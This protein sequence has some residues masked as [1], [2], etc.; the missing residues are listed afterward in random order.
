MRMERWQIP[1]AGVSLIVGLLLATQFKS[2]ADYRKLILPSRRAE[3]LVVMLRD[4]EQA[5][6]DLTQ[7]VA[8]LRRRLN[9]RGP[10]GYSGTGS[11]D[12]VALTGPGLVVTVN[13]SAKA[14]QKGED[15]NISIVH[16]DDLLRVVNEL[17]SAGAEA[18]A[19]N[20]QRMT[21]T[22]EIACAGSTILVNKTRLAP[23]FI[24]KAIGNPDTM[25]SALEMRGGIVEYLQFYGIQVKISKKSD[26]LI[27]MFTGSGL[28]KY[29]KPVVSDAAS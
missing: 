11:M 4:S 5:K 26:V 15:P 8:A 27:P 20:G 2:Q 14:L 12:N 22:S 16:N 19:I 24:L 10:Q 1:V 17:R 18:I 29:A 13:D 7:Q 9:E 21:A 28:F 6:Q 23:P 3:D 25:A